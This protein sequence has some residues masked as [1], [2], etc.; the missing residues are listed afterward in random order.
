MPGHIRQ[1]HRTA[2]KYNTLCQAIRNI[3]PDS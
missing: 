3:V 1:I 2:P